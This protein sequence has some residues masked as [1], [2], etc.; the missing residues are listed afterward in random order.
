[1]RNHKRSQNLTNLTRPTHTHKKS[2]Y[3]PVQNIPTSFTIYRTPPRDTTTRSTIYRTS[4]SFA[5]YRTSTQASPS[6]EHPHT[7]S[8]LQNIPQSL[9]STEHPLSGAIYRTFPQDPPSTEHPHKLCHIQ[10]TLTSFAIYRTSP[11]ASP[12]TEHPH[13]LH[14][15]QNIPTWRGLNIAFCTAWSFIMSCDES[16]IFKY[17]EC[18]FFFS[19]SFPPNMT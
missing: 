16:N 6:T 13:K 1:M 5:I 8:H 14:H 19:F 9:Q 4:P 15:L 17:L 12:S 11:Q 2:G 7:L 10:N 18:F 3:G